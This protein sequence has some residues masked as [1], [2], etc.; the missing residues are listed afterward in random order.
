MSLIG[1]HQ[2]DRLLNRFKSDGWHLPSAANLR[3]IYSGHEQQFGDGIFW[4]APPA[5]RSRGFNWY[6]SVPRK[7]VMEFGD[8]LS[9]PAFLLLVNRDQPDEGP[10]YACFTH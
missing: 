3:E 8:I 7:R 6:Y 1:A 4:I 9:F 10:A 2:R 5:A